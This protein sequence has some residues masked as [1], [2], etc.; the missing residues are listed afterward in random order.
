[1]NAKSKQLNNWTINGA[2]DLSSLIQNELQED[3]EKGNAWDKEKKPKCNGGKINS[4]ST[5]N[6]NL[7]YMWQ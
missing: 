1:M 4:E 6:K 7:I 2:K 3:A 5:F